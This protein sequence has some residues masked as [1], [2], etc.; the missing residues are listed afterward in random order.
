MAR[1]RIP[2]TAQC[3]AVILFTTSAC[4]VQS[5]ATAPG[6][7]EIEAIASAE[8]TAK[9]HYLANAGVLIARGA[10]KVLFDPLFRNDFGT[11]Q[12]LPEALERALFAGEP[13]FN[14]IDAVLISHYHEDH[15][16]PVDTPRLLQ[17][18]PEIPLYAPAQAVSGMRDIAA[19]SHA[20]IFERVT[21]IALEYKDAPV[22]RKSSRSRDTDRVFLHV[23]VAPVP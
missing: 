11:Y 1:K 12:L 9:A 16:S 5:D 23:K 13:P 19:D 10:T 3:V 18:R 4:S 2:I 6:S 8:S 17:K 7:S 22:S 14:G 21:P 20:A 15:F